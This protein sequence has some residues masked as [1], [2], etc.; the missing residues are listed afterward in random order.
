MRAE[1]DVDRDRADHADRVERGEASRSWLNSSTRIGT[2]RGDDRRHPRHAEA[3]EL[4]QELRQLAVAG[5]QVL[6]GDHVGDGG[7]GG[8]QQQQ[9]ADDARRPI[10]PT[11]RRNA[12]L[13]NASMSLHVRVAIEREN[14]EHEQ[15]EQDVEDRDL[16]RDDPDRLA[17]GVR[18]GLLHH[19]GEVGD[20]FDAG[21]R[22]HD[23]D[24]R[25][26]ISPGVVPANCRCACGRSAQSTCGTATGADVISSVMHDHAD[27]R[28]DREAAGVLGAHQVEHAD[29]G[30]RDDRP[31]ARRIPGEQRFALSLRVKL[32]DRL[33]VVRIVRER[34]Q[35]IVLRRGHRAFEG[36]RFCCGI[37]GDWVASL[38]EI[39]AG[40]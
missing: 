27:G 37:V 9:A 8:G 16:G 12:P 13:R 29:H 24:E 1:R 17:G 18:D 35:M 15:R 40:G 22:E 23:R 6:H 33:V 30:D 21:E 7:V 28:D 36:E 32:L 39:K 14:R 2:R 25:D 19:A 10:R 11:R 20:R 4:L 38:L 3:V 5:H 34:D 26:Q 31:E